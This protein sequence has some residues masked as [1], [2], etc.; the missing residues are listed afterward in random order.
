MG[1]LSTLRGAFLRLL[2]IIMHIQTYQMAL[3]D[4]LV[5]KVL[6]LVNIIP[7]AV[8]LSNKG[9]WQGVITDQQ[10][11]W[12][13]SVRR[14]IEQ[15]TKKKTERF[16]FNV[17]GPGHF[18]D[19]HRHFFNCYAAVLYIDVPLNSG[20]IEFRQ[21]NISKTITPEHGTL[22]VFPGTLDHRVLPN[23]SQGNRISLSTNLV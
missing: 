4:D 9:G 23:L 12:V 2:N 1:R 20:D 11:N 18:N 17:N 16:W 5:D 21:G 3:A 15:L 22:L 13:E 7:S 14:D 10:I 8:G 6:E 19:W